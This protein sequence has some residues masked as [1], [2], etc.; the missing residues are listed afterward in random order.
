MNKENRNFIILV[1]AAATISA[2]V[3]IQNTR[4]AMNPEGVQIKID[5][6]KVKREI[7]QAGL[8]PR[9]AIYWKEM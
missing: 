1:I 2:G 9:E 7:D 5:V 3:I 8:K 4:S 6:E